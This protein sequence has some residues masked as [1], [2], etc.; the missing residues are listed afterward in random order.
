MN[1][2]PLATIVRKVVPRSVRNFIRRPRATVQRI[3]S[4]I[5]WCLGH[6]STVELLDG[7][8]RLKSHPMC[9]GEF[10]VFNHDPEQ[11]MELRSFQR[12]ATQAMQ[13]LDIGTHWG[14]F[15]LAA[16][17]FGGP[18]A[19]ALGVEASCDA[20]DTFAANVRLNGA[21]SRVE[22]V[23]AAC[24]SEDGSL[25]MLTTGA[26]GADYLV[27]PSEKRPD[28]V[29]VRQVTVDGICEQNHFTPTH[30]KIDVEGFEEEVL[31]GAADTLFKAR[32][33][34]F[35]ELHGDMI[36]ARG[37]NPEDVLDLLQKVGYSVFQALDGSPLHRDELSSKRF[38]ARFVALTNT[39]NFNR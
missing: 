35:L 37:K 11:Q 19:K 26:G 14:V 4:K 25:E 39:Q 9:V 7:T 13:F 5:F 31:K 17:H 23:N 28:T 18:R 10:Q 34:I 1:S 6:A 33:V 12:H 21:T 32:P 15:T 36:R 30:V 16:M 2:S 8:W 24:G 22:I 38:N 20:A 27:I 29:T 3:T